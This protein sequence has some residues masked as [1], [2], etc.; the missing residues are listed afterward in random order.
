[1]KRLIPIAIISMV[2]VTETYAQEQSRY[3]YDFQTKRSYAALYKPV[4]NLTG[5][6]GSGVSAE[7]G[8]FLASDG[9]GTPILGYALQSKFKLADQATF[10]FG[11][12]LINAQ[13]EKPRLAILAGVS[14]RF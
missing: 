11:P 14:F 4:G 12:A 8:M 6:F 5:L 13:N 10:S 7:I 2:T 9:A 3:L 1:M